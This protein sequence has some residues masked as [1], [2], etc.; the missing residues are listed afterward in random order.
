MPTSE[1]SMHCSHLNLAMHIH[2]N[3]TDRLPVPADRQFDLCVRLCGTAHQPEAARLVKITKESGHLKPALP[4]A[5]LPVRAGQLSTLFRRASDLPGD[6]R[7]T[8]G[9]PERTHHSPVDRLHS[10]RHG[11]AVAPLVP[12]SVR[13]GLPEKSQGTH[14]VPVLDVLDVLD[15]P[16]GVPILD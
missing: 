5:R 2:L 16:D 3:S 8:A 9:L 14:T 13:S 4:A 11:I 6:R 10:H 1:H 7:S 15:V 12:R